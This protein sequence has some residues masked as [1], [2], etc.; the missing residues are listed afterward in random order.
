MKK[1][2]NIKIEELADLFKPFNIE[3]VIRK[4]AEVYYKYYPKGDHWVFK[5]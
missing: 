4:E 5:K 2:I 1:R 3:R